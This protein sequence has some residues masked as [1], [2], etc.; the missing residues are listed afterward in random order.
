MTGE[1]LATTKTNEEPETIQTRSG[2]GVALHVLVL[3]CWMRGKRFPNQPNR[4]SQWDNNAH[5]RVHIYPADP[6]SHQD[7]RWS[8]EACIWDLGASR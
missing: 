8:G 7:P 6:L 3:R 4:E 5:T 1:R 2:H